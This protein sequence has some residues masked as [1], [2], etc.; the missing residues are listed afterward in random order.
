MSAQQANP[1]EAGPATASGHRPEATTPRRSVADPGLRIANPHA[2]GI[3]VHSREHWVCVPV[4]SVPS[5]P[6]GQPA[7][8]PANVRAF[9]TC[10]PDLEQLADW[11]FACGVTT[12]AM[13]ATGV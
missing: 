5:G 3:D 8:V 6:R 12:V 1:S 9:G 10:T 2:A 11:L 7:N 13:E 4:A